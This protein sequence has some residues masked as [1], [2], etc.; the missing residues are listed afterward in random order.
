M[1]QNRAVHGRNRQFVDIPSHIPTC[2]SPAPHP[3]GVGVG[4]CQPIRK[5]STQRPLNQP[6]GKMH[7]LSHYISSDQNKQLAQK[8][9]KEAFFSLGSILLS[10]TP[11]C[12]RTVTLCFNKSYH[13]ISS[14]ASMTSFFWF[15]ETMN[16]GQLPLTSTPITLQQR[17]HQ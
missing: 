8:P 6:I 1:R 17:Q 10:G 7:V 5:K 13:F 15:L 9:I 4:T 2:L 3:G 12:K 11:A 14:F 16:S